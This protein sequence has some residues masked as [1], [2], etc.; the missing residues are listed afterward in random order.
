MTIK[1]DVRSSDPAK[2]IAGGGEQAPVGM[3]LGKVVSIE[4][5][6]ELKDNP[7]DDLHVVYEITH[8]AEGK[9]ADGYAQLHDYVGFSDSQVWKMDQL[10]QALGAASTTKRTGEFD[11]KKQKGKKVK[12]R[13][14]G[15]TYNEE[16][17]AKPGGVWKADGG[18]TAGSE[19]EPTDE[20][21]AEETI[22]DGEETWAAFG[23]RIDAEEA[24]DEEVDEITAAAEEAG[25][26]P[27][28]YDTWEALGVE[29]DEGSGED[30]G[31]DAAE[32]D[33]GDADGEAEEEGGDDEDVPY[34][35][36]SIADLKAE[37]EARE[38]ATSGSKS[39]LVKRLEENDEEDG[40]FDE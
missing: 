19:D 24:S 39:A 16:Y 38:L 36:W 5:R 23:A 29:L 37:C 25:L 40:P 30:E 28:S 35:Q 13:V 9:K 10:L 6:R 1:F 32:E 14:K 31:E 2:A 15:E 26:D 34:D 3:Y 12:I 8:T 33:E 11:E 27:D 4:D 22:E 20:E 21:E 7:K 17:R 18:A